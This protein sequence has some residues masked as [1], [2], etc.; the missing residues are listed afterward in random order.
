[1]T[2][3]LPAAQAT[4]ELVADARAALGEG[5]TWDAERG[6]LWWV[7]ITAGR[8][9]RFDPRTGEDAT[10][11]V[12]SP[13]GAVALSRD[14]R[15]VAAVVAGLALLDPATWRAE[16]LLAL[17]AGDPPLRCNDAKCDPAGRLWVGRMGLG[18]EPGAGALLRVDADLA[19]STWL[20]GLTIPN[21]LGWSPDGRT[22]Y[23]TDSTWGE[24]RA[25][26][27]DPST[28]AMG[29]GRSLAR[30]AEGVAVTDGLTVDAEGFL[31][32]ALWGGSRVVR[33]APDGAVV[34]R[35]DLPVSRVTSCAFGGPDLGDLY[36]TTAGGA[37][38]ADDAAGAAKPHAGG[39]FRCRPGVRG[40]PPVAFAG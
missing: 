6:V 3:Q 27:Y 17:D 7:D 21:G 14:G 24:V 20:T 35:L 36:V 40:L 23:F 30:L 18:T 11:E 4:L 13:V 38:P 1:M 5:P 12:G 31:W 37:D 16:A 34:G 29:D 26:P 8:V 25:F 39:L 2:T 32:V 33:V 15:L 28:G 22:M 10:I 19:V 9:H